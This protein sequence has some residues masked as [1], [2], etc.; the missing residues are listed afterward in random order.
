M[1]FAERRIAMQDGLSIYVRDYASNGA[2]LPVVCLHGLT[3]NSR[4][5][6][7][8]A[9]WLVSLGRRAIAIDARGRGLS[10]DDP[11]PGRYR[12]DVYLGDALRALDALGVPRAVFL[13][14]SM[15]GVMTMIAATVAASRIAAAILNDIGPEIDPR[16]LARIAAYVGKAGPFATWDEMIAA[17]KAAQ[18]PLFPG[19]DDAFWSAFARR[20]AREREGKVEFAYDPA[21]ARAFAP[22]G[23]EPPP[24]MI[25]LFTALAQRPVLVLRGALSDLLSPQGVAAMTRIK[26]DLDF[27]EIPD[28][29]HAPTLDEPE[30]RRAIEDFLAGIE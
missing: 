11:D 19:K 2:R 28:V 25:P 4:D 8:V 18:G 16:G 22:R 20:V 21:I 24:S 1:S 15:G 10:D 6:E 7:T 29:G 13:G 30:A 5:F 14:T 23:A 3:R 26:P 17:V 27:A 12:P 9:P